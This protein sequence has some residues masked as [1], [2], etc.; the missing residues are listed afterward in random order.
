MAEF[1]NRYYQNIHKF[2]EG[3]GT[4]F[5]MPPPKNAYNSLETW[6]EFTSPSL[7]KWCKF[8]HRM[9]TTLRPKTGLVEIA[10]KDTQLSKVEAALSAFA[11][12]D[13][14]VLKWQPW[15]IC[16]NRN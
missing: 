7:P 11:G 3:H 15:P 1:K 10:F 4:D 2:N 13:A 6:F 12:F 9:R 8:R 16:C 14:P 5:F